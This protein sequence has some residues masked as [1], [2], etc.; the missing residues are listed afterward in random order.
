MECERHE[1]AQPLYGTVNVYR[2][3]D[4]LVD[5]G[6][7]SEQSRKVVADALNGGTLTGVER[8][9]L[10]H[11]HIDH[12]GGSQTLPELA[13]LPHVVFEGV[14]SIITDFRSYLER[15]RTEIDERSGGL[16][17]SRSAIDESYFTLDD[18]VES[19]IHVGQVVEDGDTILLD[20]NECE[21]IHT[22]GHSAHHMALW[23]ADS[24]TMISADLVAMNGH[25]MYGP[26]YGDVGAYIDSLE[27]LRT[28]NANRLV[29]GHGPVMDNPTARI[30]DALDK[31]RDA[32]I[33]IK[34]A[35][36]S[37]DGPVTANRLAREVFGAGDATVGF[38]T[39]VI[40]EYFDHLADEG[41]L[42]VSYA[43]D[44]V[45]AEPL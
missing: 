42:S 40:C 9:V 14:P 15:V 22:P 2:V 11:P 30:D 7:V 20:K 39:L 26:L 19:D 37:A 5:T 8:V 33:S 28:Y 4:T 16:S 21:V 18:R 17:G 43:D 38:L 45:Y 32:V 29:P 6:H 24:R 1:L 41:E 31:V 23:H 3:G 34:T 44:G 12:V 35:V 25:F 13:D 27:R 10:T 36:A